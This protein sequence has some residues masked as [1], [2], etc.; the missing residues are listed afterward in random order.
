MARGLQ[1]TGL[2]IAANLVELHMLNRYNAGQVAD[3]DIVTTQLTA[4]SARRALA[5][6]IASRQDA[7]VALIRALGWGL[8]GR[9]GV[10]QSGR[11]TRT[12]PTT[13]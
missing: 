11:A 1:T 5:R 2:G 9:R 10:S 12:T 13:P 3:A 8:A 4:P 6:T 7:A